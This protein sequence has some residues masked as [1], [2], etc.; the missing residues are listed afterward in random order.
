MGAWGLGTLDSD[1][2]LDFLG[3]LL[4]SPTAQPVVVALREAADPQ[5]TWI[6]RV[7]QWWGATTLEEVRESLRD[8]LDTDLGAALPGAIALR[9]GI[10]C[11]FEGAL[12]DD[13]D[14]GLAAAEVVAAAFGKPSEDLVTTGQDVM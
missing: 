3:N 12:V 5:G 11:G 4:K 10:E 9:D 14:V 2:A 1:S 8:A 7:L 6:A 13:P